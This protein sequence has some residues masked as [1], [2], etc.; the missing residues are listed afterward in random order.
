M[1]P[2]NLQILS[3]KFQCLDNDYDSC[4][5]VD[6]R[7]GQIY[8]F[9]KSHLALAGFFMDGDDYEA[10]PSEALEIERAKKFAESY[11]RNEVVDF[12]DRYEFSTYAIMEE[13]IAC[14]ENPSV[15]NKLHS[16]IKERGAF[17]RFRDTA[18]SL[19]LLDDWFA[20]KDRRFLEKTQKWCS[21]NGI[22]FEPKT[23]EIGEFLIRP[24]AM[25]ELAALS[26]IYKSARQYMA[27]NGNLLQWSGG[28]PAKELLIGDIKSHQL[29]AVVS[30]GKICGVFAF[31]LGPEP[32]YATID[33]GAWLNANPYG[34]VHRLASDGSKSGI[35][36]ACLKFCLE[37]TDNVRTDTHKDNK[38]MQSLLQANGFAKCGTIYVQDGE[39]DHSP[40][41]A[42]HY[43]R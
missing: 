40:R 13:Y 36:D 37:F 30:N 25:G 32:T 43:K 10:H 4:N 9:F 26:R 41:L 22:D 8:S 33:D 28:Y 35:F 6:K 3:E 34:T 19:G 15:A 21:L 39:S 11:D 1:N 38:K 14:Q 20:Y 23:S 17:G 5:F 31:I 27:N 12:P 2:V 16:A 24:A 42:Y 18:A 7:D 29:Y